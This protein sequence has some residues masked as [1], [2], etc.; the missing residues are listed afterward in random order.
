MSGWF[1]NAVTAI[2][3]ER[4]AIWF[5]DITDASGASRTFLVEAMRGQ[6][7]MFFYT[8]QM[9]LLSLLELMYISR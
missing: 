8:L 2:D 1:S 5:R 6:F 3:G 4:I 9:V 7:R